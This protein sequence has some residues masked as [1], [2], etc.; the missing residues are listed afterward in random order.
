[1]PNYQ[2][3]E[4]YNTTFYRILFYY[5]GA[6]H[7]HALGRLLSIFRYSCA[8]T[9]V[10]K[11]R[12]SIS[13]FFKEHGK[14]LVFAYGGHGEKRICFHEPKQFR[15]SNKIWKTRIKLPDPYRPIHSKVTKTKVFTTCFA[16]G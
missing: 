2:I 14:Q 9:I 10:T 8:M 11:H 5:S 6:S 1:M 16:C 3:V 13:K 7:R 4:L 12:S 15:E